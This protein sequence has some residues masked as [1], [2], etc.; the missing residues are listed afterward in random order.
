[1]VGGRGMR[2]ASE[3]RKAGGETGKRPDKAS[4]EC[5]RRRRRAE[6]GDVKMAGFYLLFGTDKGRRLDRD[7]RYDLKTG[8]VVTLTWS[9]GTRAR[10]VCRLEPLIV[11]VRDDRVLSPPP[12]LP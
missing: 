11:P 4:F 2:N 9:D 5:V 7:V 10:L 12:S 8:V 6:C 1:M 3:T